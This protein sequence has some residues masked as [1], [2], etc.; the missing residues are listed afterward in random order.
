MRDVAGE[1]EDIHCASSLSAALLLLNAI[2]VSH[3]STYACS[4][5]VLLTSNIFVLRL[6][7]RGRCGIRGVTLR[8]RKYA[9]AREHTVVLVTHSPVN[10]CCIDSACSS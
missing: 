4:Y 8:S 2:R 6:A 10:A 1:A 7:G 9:P 5:T 3:A